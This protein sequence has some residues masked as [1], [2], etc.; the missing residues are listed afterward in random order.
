MTTRPQ[1]R[2]LRVMISSRC[3]TP[4]VSRSG[5]V[6]MTDVRERAKDEVEKMLAYG[7]RQSAYE[8]WINEPSE[9]QESDDTW[10]DDSLDQARQAD[11]VIVLFSGDP[12]SGLEGRVEGVCHGEFLAARTDAPTKVRVIDVRPAIAPGFEVPD[13][14]PAWT[15]FARD[16]DALKLITALPK[17]DTEAVTAIKQAVAAATHTLALHGV[18]ASRRGS[19]ALGEALDWRRLDFRHRRDVMQQ[20]ALDRLERMGASILDTA[21]NRAIHRLSPGAPVLVV[22]KAAPEGLS[23]ASSREMVGQPHRDDHLLVSELDGQGA[24]GPLHVV[25]VPARATQSQARALIGSADVMIVPLPD[26]VWV[27]D[28]VN[29]AQVL[30]IGGC[31]DEGST[32]LAIENAFGWLHRSGEVERLVQRARRRTEILRVMAEDD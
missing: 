13:D 31:A 15:A 4:I 30:V 27:A 19:R 9:S 26:G 2:P 11:I 25:P 10:Y 22:V 16:V 29:R 24:I 7:N 17:K 8:V 20:A 6:P 12:G 21:G 1:D 14:D 5:T 18:K 32:G 3:S 23:L 28:A